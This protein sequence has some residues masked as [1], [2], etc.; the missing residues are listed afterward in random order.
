MK[1]IGQNGGLCYGEQKANSYNN[2]KNSLKTFVVVVVVCC[3]ERS[4]K[5]IIFNLNIY[6]LSQH[7]GVETDW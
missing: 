3:C 7:E 1:R 4:K 5:K 2:R 6:K